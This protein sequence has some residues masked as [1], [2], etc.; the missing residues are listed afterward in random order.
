MYSKKYKNPMF[1]LVFLVVDKC[2]VFFL[3][4]VLEKERKDRTIHMRSLLF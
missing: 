1:G 3:K 2:F 4:P